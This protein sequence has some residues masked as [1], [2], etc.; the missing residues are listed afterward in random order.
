MQGLQPL[1]KLLQVG[2]EAYRSLRPCIARP[3]KF[4]LKVSYPTVS[5]APGASSC[6]AQEAARLAA[7]WRWHRQMGLF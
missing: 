6:Q 1:N 3:Y 5:R 2:I 4:F 7:Q